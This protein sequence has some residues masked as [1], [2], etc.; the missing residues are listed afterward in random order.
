MFARF[1]LPVKSRP[2]VVNGGAGLLAG[3]PGELFSVMAFTIVNGRITRLDA[4]A[5][6][7]RLAALDLTF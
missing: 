3:D 4:V 7:D 2:V 6:P 1:G 5:D